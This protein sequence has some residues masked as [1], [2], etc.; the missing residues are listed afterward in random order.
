MTLKQILFKT[1]KAVLQPW[2][3]LTRGHTL[4][5]RAV[6]FNDAGDVLLVRHRYASGWHFP[7][8]GVEPGETVEQ[9]VVRELAEEAGITAIGRPKLFAL[10]ANFERFPRDH[11]AVCLIENWVPGET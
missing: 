9:A 8:G 3:R 4:G 11:V 7:G 1:L 10:Y 6:V 2:W 5:V